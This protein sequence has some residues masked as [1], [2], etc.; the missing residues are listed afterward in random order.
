MKKKGFV[1][2]YVPSEQEYSPQ[3]I[4]QFEQKEDVL[5]RYIINQLLFQ[6]ASKN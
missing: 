5:I 1:I 2:R 3:Q 6:E 4:E